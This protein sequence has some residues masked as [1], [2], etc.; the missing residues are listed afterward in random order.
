GWG[1]T[2]GAIEEAVDRAT[3]Q[4]LSVSSLHLRYLSP[5]EVGLAEIF[6]KFKKVMTVEINYSDQ[7]ETTPNPRPAQL[8]LLLRA[9]LMRE[10]DFWSIVPGQPLG[11]GQIVE[12]IREELRIDSTPQKKKIKK[13][14]AGK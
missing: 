7:A 4:G 2:L 11:P 5:M 9:H 1:S 6:S 8:A 12:V 3:A 10:I 14:G 13:A